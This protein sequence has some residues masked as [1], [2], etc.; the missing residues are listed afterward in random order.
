MNLHLNKELFREFID[1]LNA[2]TSIDSDIIEKDY[3]VCTILKELSKKQDELH[4]YFKGGTAIYK[5]LDT[6]NR[7]SEDIDLTVKIL[8]EQSNTKNKNR[9]KESA[10]GYKISGLELSKDECIDNKG[11]VTGIYRYNSIYDI[12]KDPLHRAGII[13]VEA[14]SF[15]VSEPYQKYTI[16]P[17]IYKLSNENEKNILE[18][19]FEIS[20]FDIN[21]I[22]LERMFIDKIFA[23]EFY[24]IRKMYKDVSKH[25]YDISVLSQNENIEKLLKNKNEME[26]LISYKRQEEKIR[27]GG[28]D[29]NTKIKDFNYF[30]LDFN[31]ELIQEFNNMQYKYVL[32]DKYKITM[33]YTKNVILEIYNFIKNI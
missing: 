17:L 24:Y 20:K 31:D 1:N 12:N 10:L 23:A 29:S 26:K 18:T 9:L 3:Y 28:I 30:K 14:T 6:M 16:E 25:L 27:I 22:K 15:T 13:Q 8:P 19:Q 5:I 11:S 4:A 2:R 32:D 7:F 21:I 33:D